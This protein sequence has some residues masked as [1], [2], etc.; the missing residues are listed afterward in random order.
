MLCLQ[1]FSRTVLSILG[2]LGDI[3][4]IYGILVIF[5]AFIVGWYNDK[6]Y[7]IEAVIANFKVRTNP[8]S[9]E[10]TNLQNAPVL[11]ERE[12]A[13]LTIV[14]KFKY[15]GYSLSQ[16]LFGCARKDGYKKLIELG[17]SKLDKSLDIMTL[18]ETIR[19]VNIFRKTMLNSN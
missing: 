18:I 19:F 3:G 13:Q 6:V 4:G 12:V 11:G 10:L 2:W 8:I 5:F 1:L 9:Q 14:T 15:L 16:L 7:Q 17:S